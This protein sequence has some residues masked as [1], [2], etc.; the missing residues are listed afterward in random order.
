M[1]RA[2]APS[3]R[4]LIVQPA[5]VRP[6]GPRQPGPLANECRNW[7]SCTVLSGAMTVAGSANGST[8]PAPARIVARE[9][10]C[11]GGPAIATTA[12]SLTARPGIGAA[13]AMDR[14]MITW[15]PAWAT[16]EAVMLL[17]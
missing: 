11:Q 9:L 6:Q 2:Q 4:C 1:A 13:R 15:R 8:Y 17:Q 12:V 3:H 5:A 14:Y 7:A 10:C 16:R